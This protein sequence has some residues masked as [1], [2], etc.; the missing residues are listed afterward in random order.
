VLS[1]GKT[2]ISIAHRIS[3]IQDSDVI[4][5]IADSKIKEQGTYN[6]LMQQKGEFYLIATGN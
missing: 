1:K 2:S 4:F 3:T 5:V 6:E